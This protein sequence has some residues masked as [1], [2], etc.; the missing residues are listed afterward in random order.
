MTKAPSFET[1]HSNSNFKKNPLKIKAFQE[2]SDNM[3]L[4]HTGF[5]FVQLEIACV[6]L[7]CLEMLIYTHMRKYLALQVVWKKS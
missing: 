6:F 5:R 4:G 1:Y 3:E 2:L 7:F